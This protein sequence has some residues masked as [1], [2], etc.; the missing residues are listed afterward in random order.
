M[1]CRSIRPVFCGA[2]PTQ[3][4]C[5]LRANL[6]FCQ[7]NA[8]DGRI[9]LQRL[10]QRLE[11]ATDQDLRLIPGP[12]RQNSTRS[13]RN[14]ETTAPNHPS[15]SHAAAFSRAHPTSGL[16]TLGANLVGK[17]VNV[18]DGLVNLQRLGQGLE[19]ATDQGWQAGV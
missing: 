5:A 15:F 6:I 1:T 12:S 10:G 3:G 11:A 16:G 18:C 9:D 14:H 13:K 7:I 4:L 8:R 19:A 2:H 17:Q